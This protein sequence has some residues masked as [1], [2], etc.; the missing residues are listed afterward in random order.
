[1]VILSI[2]IEV[3]T[4]SIIPNMTGFE[5]TE[6]SGHMSAVCHTWALGNAQDHW[7]MDDDLIHGVCIHLLSLVSS[8]YL[9]IY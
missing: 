4:V 7:D 1:M 9:Y 3:N 6:V 8:S 2:Y 5:I